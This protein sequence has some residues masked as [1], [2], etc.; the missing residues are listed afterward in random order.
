MT[1]TAVLALS[2]HSHNAEMEGMVKTIRELKDNMTR[3]CL[4]NFYFPCWEELFRSLKT[5]PDILKAQYQCNW[6][7]NIFSCTG[8]RKTAPNYLKGEPSVDISKIC[9]IFGEGE[10][11]A[12]NGEQI[13]DYQSQLWFDNIRKQRHP[14]TQRKETLEISYSADD[15]QHCSS[16][17][18]SSKMMQWQAT[19]SIFRYRWSSA[20]SVITYEKLLLSE[21]D[22]GTLDASSG[23]W[24]TNVPG[25]YGFYK[26]ASPLGQRS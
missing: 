5:T 20:S 15:S 6:K 1:S 10:K 26:H 16:P 3:F 9:S 19:G 2:L 12:F 7:H 8:F 22:A 11:C 13:M 25:L 21:G 14:I 24:T 23:V 17:W 18:Q 4:S